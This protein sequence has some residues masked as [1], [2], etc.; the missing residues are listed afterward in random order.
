MEEARQHCFTTG[1]GLPDWARFSAQ[2]GNPGC[3]AARSTA[4]VRV[5][6]LGGQSQ[7]G[8]PERGGSN[9]RFQSPEANSRCTSLQWMLAVG[10]VDKLVL[11]GNTALVRVSQTFDST[12]RGCQISHPIWQP[13]RQNKGRDGD[14]VYRQMHASTPT[15][16]IN[17]YIST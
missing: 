7:S 2:S 12:H 15:H 16:L 13:S 9:S 3:I 8:N 10:G 14:R 11:F 5:A 6:R 4:A 1:A 17:I